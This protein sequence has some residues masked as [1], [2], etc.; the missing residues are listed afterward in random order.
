LHFAKAIN[1]VEA[2][3]PSGC[4]I[5]SVLENKHRYNLGNA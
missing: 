5:G 2:L 3:V 1:V 4:L